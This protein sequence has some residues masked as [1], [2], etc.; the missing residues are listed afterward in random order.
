MGRHPVDRKKIAV[1]EKLGREA[2]TSWSVEKNW[3][4]VTLLKVF[5]ETGRTHQIR[6]HL[7]HLNHPVVGDETYGGGKRRARQ[8]RSAV[9]R[10]LLFPVERQML[11]AF[12][13]AFEHPVRGVPL[14]FQAPLSPDF[15]DLLNSLEEISSSRL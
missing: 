1:V 7:S 14:S 12:R 9:L 4:E 13:L 5:I 11:H 3:G 8:V 10:E 6:V 15:M 2:V